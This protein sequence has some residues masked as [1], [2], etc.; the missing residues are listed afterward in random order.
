[1]MWRLCSAFAHGRSW[2]SLSWLERQVVR[3]EDGVLNLRLTG[4]DV[5][6]VITVALLP[7]VFTSWA[8]QLYERR[9]RSPYP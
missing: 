7:F 1:V 8:L 2:A 4:G 3:S 5:E 6:R 9:R